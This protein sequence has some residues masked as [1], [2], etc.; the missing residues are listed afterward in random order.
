MIKLARI[1]DEQR[2]INENI[3]AYEKRLQSP[4][5][6]FID[7]NPTFVT[8]YHISNVDTTV[9]EGWKDTEEVIGPNS[10]LR[11]KKITDFPV[12]GLSQMVLNLQ[13]EDQG[14]DVSYEGE[15]VILPHT[16]KPNQNDFFVIN[17]LK[18]HDTYLFRVTGIEYDNIHPDNFYKITFRLEETDSAQEDLLG[19]QVEGSYIC[20]NDNI[21]TD[22]SCII[23]SER[24]SKLKDIELLYR[25]IAETYISIFYNEQYNTLLGEKPCG[26]K[27]YDPYMIEFVNKYG[28]FN[29]K[30][31][32]KTYIFS[33]EV[34]D[35]R[36]A[37]KYEKSVWKFIERQDMSIM[38]NFYYYIYPGITLPYTS[39]A[40]W[41]D[42]SVYVL[43][44][45]L[46]MN[47]AELCDR[48]FI[49][50]FIKDVKENLPVESDYAKLLKGYIRKDKITAYDVPLDLNSCL[51]TL[52]A[53]LEFFF[54][55]PIILFI[56]KKILHDEMVNKEFS[57][58]NTNTF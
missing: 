26:K 35:K 10:S 29:D 1:I 51:L 31:R 42:E 5:N 19:R 46:D 33:Q 22:E 40:N 47:S 8:Y 24:W 17:H 32:I 43:D 2:N 54:I 38:N 18:M 57:A 11:F 3:F 20:I 6:K 14:L 36:F 50:E 52:D 28:L 25:D 13:E 15:G 4:Y 21:G 23:E 39:F 27:L 56:L 7:K 44:I 34:Q 12:Y 9:N 45:S 49:D 58:K 53:N 30:K 16:I 48:I 41:R 37:I 55:T